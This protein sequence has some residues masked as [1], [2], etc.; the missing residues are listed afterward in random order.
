MTRT[1]SDGGLI[2]LRN[3]LADNRI[4]RISLE[5]L[6]ASFTEKMEGIKMIKRRFGQGRDKNT[7]LNL[8]TKG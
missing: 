6:S 3:P 7:D 4:H 8:S 2:I 1:N 5:K